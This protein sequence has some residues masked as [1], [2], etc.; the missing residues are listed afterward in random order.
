MKNNDYQFEF[1]E[2]RKEIEI[3]NEL[4]S[5]LPSR[6][7]L[8]GKGRRAKRSNHTLINTI[9]AVFTLI[10]ILIF[11]YVIYNFYNQNDS[12][13]TAQIED[14]G[15]QY[16]MQTSPS[17]GGGDASQAGGKEDED[18]E[19]GN[20]ESKEQEN[21]KLDQAGTGTTTHVTEKPEQPK[22]PVKQETV[23]PEKKPEQKPEKKQENKQVAN[24]QTGKVHVVKKDETLYRISVNY[25]GSDVG[26]NKIKQA[27]GLSS[28]EIRVGQKLIIP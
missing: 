17:P 3:D 1:E 16:Q 24:Q 6:S 27:N 13:N 20:T 22:Q 25:Y 10:P 15:V 18:K 5:E 21:G 4:N 19:D 14:N 28:N 8:H 23:K 9:L 7:E 26:I 2:H 11:G 12:S